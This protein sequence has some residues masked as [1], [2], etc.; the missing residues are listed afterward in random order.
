MLSASVK[1]YPSDLAPPLTSPPKNVCILE[2]T[3]NRVT[4]ARLP[5]LLTLMLCA[6][7]FY[8]E[9]TSGRIQV[10]IQQKPCT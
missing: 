6:L 10:H 1:N 5:R 3:V 8:T 7:M 2:R 9:H 4:A